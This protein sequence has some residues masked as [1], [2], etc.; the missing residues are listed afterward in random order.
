MAW[1]EEKVTLSRTP[2]YLFNE[3]GTPYDI[4]YDVGEGWHNLCLRTFEKIADAYVRHDVDL[5]NFSLI[6]MKEKF[7]GLRIYLGSMET[8][9]YDDVYAIVCGAEEESY[10]ICEKCGKPGKPRSGGWI[11]TLCF[12]HAKE[13]R[14]KSL[15]EETI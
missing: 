2:P 13:L 7:G 3:D 11:K 8:G 14:Y 1:Y 9:L 15:E 6:Q 10:T 4:T 12:E 5:S